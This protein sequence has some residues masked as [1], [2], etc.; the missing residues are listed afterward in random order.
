M[1]AG[2]L[3]AVT[4][5]LILLVEEQLE[6]APFALAGKYLV[7]QRYE[8]GAFTVRLILVLG[9]LAAGWFHPVGLIG[10]SAVALGAGLFGYL[11]PAGREFGPGR[12]VVPADAEVNRRFRAYAWNG[13]PTMLHTM[14]QSQIGV[15][16]VAVFGSTETVADLGAIGKMILLFGI[17]LAVVERIFVARLAVETDAVRLRRMWLRGIVFAAVAGTC[18]V[19]AVAWTGPRLVW[20]LGESYL[21]L[22]D[23]LVWYAVG[24]AYV[25]VAAAAFG[26]LPA[27]GWMRHSWVTPLVVLGA[28]ALAFPWI[29]AGT[30]RGMIWLKLAGDVAGSVHGA[31]LLARGFSGKGKL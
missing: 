12:G 28:Q 26:L 19:G 27:R 2:L 31:V 18:I 8:L 17:P 5:N 16:L 20:L 10:A 1:A 14:I 23:D 11:K 3:G 13:V 29:D 15:V 7:P 30:V 9:L 6:A 21:A 4:V 22:A 24:Q 25:L